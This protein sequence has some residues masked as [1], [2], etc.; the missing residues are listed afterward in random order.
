MVD[1]LTNKQKWRKTNVSTY[2]YEDN[3][4][5]KILNMFGSDLNLVEE[6]IGK[7]TPIKKPDR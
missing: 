1:F 4:L 3:I 2:L 7:I 5:Y 6:S